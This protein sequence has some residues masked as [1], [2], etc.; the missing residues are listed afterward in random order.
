MF[1]VEPASPTVNA[2]SVLS[3]NDTIKNQGPHSASAFTVNYHLSP[4]AV[5]GGAGDINLATNST[6]ASR[7]PGPPLAGSGGTNSATTNHTVL[8]T[9][10]AGTYYVCAKIMSASPAESSIANNTLCS[11]GTV[12]VPVSDLSLSALSTTYTTAKV[13]SIIRVS[14]SVTNVGGSRANAA[15][16]VDLQASLTPV[17]APGTN[18]YRAP[19]SLLFAGQIQTLASY[20]VRM[21]STPGTYYVCGHVDYLVQTNQTVNANDTA[22]T[23]TTINVTP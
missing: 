11:T 9:V 15:S 12:T 6:L 18:T 14:L 21:P 16:K 22:C 1:S 2:G 13:N 17:Y 4:D 20:P 3:I 8:K 19:T 23:G 5:Y 10:K 7:P